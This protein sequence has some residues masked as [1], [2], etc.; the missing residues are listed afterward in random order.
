MSRPRAHA[1]PTDPHT[2]IRV[3]LSFSSGGMVGRLESVEAAALVVVEAATSGT[4]GV[5]MEETATKTVVGVAAGVIDT[6][7]PYAL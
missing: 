2:L 5:A 1:P 7:D 3:V 4:P 6:S